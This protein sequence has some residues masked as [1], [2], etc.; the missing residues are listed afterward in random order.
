MLLATAVVLRVGTILTRVDEN[1]AEGLYRGTLAKAI[2]DGVPFW[3]AHAPEIPHVRGSVVI[4]FL[5]APFYALFGPT[6]A[7]LRISGLIFHLA[8]V[9]A[10]MALV[11]RLLG[12][13]AAV[14]AST[15]LVFAPP[16]LAKLSVL[17][18]GDHIES[19]PFIAGVA[20]LGFTWAF[21]EGPPRYVLAVATG[22]LAA[23]AVGFHAQALLG[24]AAFAVTTVL[25]APGVVRR[26][27]FW[28]GVV[29]GFA[30]GL[31]PLLAGNR[32]TGKNALSLFG[33]NPAE[34][35]AGGGISEK[36]DKLERFWSHDLAVSFQYPWRGLAW[37]TL[38]LAA[39]C[40]VALVVRTRGRV[41]RP[42]LRASAFFVV[43][44]AIFV[45]VYAASGSQFEVMDS[46][47]N[48]LEVRYPQPIVP[49]LL[50]PIAVVAARRWESGRRAL[51]V[52]VAAPVLALGLY[53]S[54]STWSWRA[55]VEEPARRGFLW[56]EFD[57]HLAYASLGDD[58]RRELRAAERE[59]G[60]RPDRDSLATR[61]ISERTRDAAIV[62]RIH[63]IDPGEEWSLPLRYAAP[64][65]PFA[66]EAP[67]ETAALVEW[68]ASVTP[69]VRP[70]CAAAAGARLA[71][72]PQLDGETMSELAR[73]ATSPAES[74]ALVRGF[75][76]GLLELAPFG[77]VR[78]FDPSVAA[79]RIAALPPEIRRDDVAFGFGFR[80]GRIVTEFYPQGDELVGRVI[81]G[82]PRE[83]QPAFARGLGAGYRM[84]FLVPPPPTLGSP[85][86]QRIV[87]LLPSDL[88]APFRHGLGHADR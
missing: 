37:I 57:G 84:R 33:K 30:F 21:A 36:L 55:M 56:E 34:H 45:V 19:F 62:A 67:M 78:F 31:V 79:A 58:E 69:I 53:G 27:D 49:F 14:L 82:F 25:L 51:A 3:P 20:A 46:T 5:A 23:L 71:S 11:W 83:L 38:A 28:L 64:R 44:P 4:S 35:L 81:A 63:E 47:A 86:V 42:T 68:M 29:P 15:L 65:V 43:Y 72:A 9:V 24:A 80:V 54:L 7:S 17:S 74:L 75:G 73:Q 66:H 32:I 52:A 39:A 60:M 85:A 2:A 1:F 40:A 16:A 22:F 6:T 61:W 48:A 8:A 10:W 18:Y 77:R 41:D 13:R 70:F 12:A 26:R 59:W 88:E 76:Q 87:R 50:L